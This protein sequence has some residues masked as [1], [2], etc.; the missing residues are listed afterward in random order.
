VQLGAAELGDLIESYGG[1]YILSSAAYNTG[2]GRVREWISRYGDPREPKVDPVDWV[3]RS[4]FAETRN[5]VQRVLENLQV[6]RL[7]FGGSQSSRPL[8]LKDLP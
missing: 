4:S 2:R 7:R 8:A 3:E 5:Y 1:S 6:Y